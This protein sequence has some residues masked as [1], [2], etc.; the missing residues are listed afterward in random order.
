VKVSDAE[1]IFH[2]YFSVKYGFKARVRDPT[3][4]LHKLEDRD[5]LFVDALDG[6]VLNPMPER[7]LGI[8]KT[9]KNIASEAAYAQN[10]RTMKLLQEL[11]HREA[12]TG[13]TVE[14]KE[15]YKINKLEPVI[16]PRQAI[17]AAREYIIERNTQKLTYVPK[18]EGNDLFS[19]RSITY[20]PKKTDIRIISKD[21]VVIPRWSIEF[22]SFKRT[23]RKEILACS[24]LTIE[25]TMRYCP[26]HIKIGAITLAPKT[27]AVCEICGQSLCDKHVRNCPICQKWLCEDDGVECSVCK[28][29]FCKEHQLISCSICNEPLCIPC[30]TTCPICGKT[31]GINHIITCDKCKKDACPNCMIT[32][33]I[34]KKNRTCKKCVK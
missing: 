7:G 10:D 20:V 5:N 13:Y 4:Q 14:I 3:K 26:K 12:I 11:N 27:I 19:Q 9:L 22:E 25:D 15:D 18:S 8:I 2:P 6:K 23:Y 24:G 33:G 29:R 31:Y 28:N 21:I 17:E 32:T 16:K 1:L 30:T 34:L